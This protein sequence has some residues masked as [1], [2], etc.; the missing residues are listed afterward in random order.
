MNHSVRKFAVRTITLLV[1][2]MFG[3]TNQQ[4]KSEEH[5]TLTKAD[6]DAM[7]HSVSNWGRWGKEDQLG[8]VNLITAAK[9]RQAAA[10]VREG[11]SISLAHDA[12]KTNAFGSPPF[13]QKMLKSGQTPGSTGSD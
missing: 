6:F 8:A 7:M 2:L 1:L 13:E 5:R 10:L 11:V 9:R 3:G 12:I 4:S